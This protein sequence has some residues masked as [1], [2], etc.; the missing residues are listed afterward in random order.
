MNAIVV[1]GAGQAGLQIAECLR[2][3]GHSGP[4][5]LLGDERWPPYQR[6]PLSKKYLG[7]SVADERLFFRPLDYL[8][9]QAIDFR[10][11]TQVVAID[12]ANTRVLLANGEQLVYA[13]LALATGARPRMLP[14]PGAEHPAVCYLRGL[15][16][17]QGLLVKLAAAARVVVIGGGFIGL[18]VAATAC[19]AGKTVTV[20]EASE[21]L[22]ARAVAP[23]VSQ[24][25]AD[26]HR[27]QGVAL[28][29]G[30]QVTRLVPLA[31]GGLSVELNDGTALPAD[32]VLVGVGGL[33]NQELAAQAGLTCANGIVVDEFARTSDP[34]IV[35]AGDCTWHINR[36]YPTPL[37]LESVQNAVDQ[38]KIAASS[39]LGLAQPYQDLPWFWS[40]Q[41][42]VKLQI[43]GLSQS[44]DTAVV[45][46][47]AASGAFSVF[48]FAAGA[49]VAVDSVNR[50]ADHMLARKLLSASRAVT[51]G[52]AAD[53]NFDLKLLL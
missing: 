39:L 19:A 8:A 2:R 13:G 9:K 1:V 26:L 45:R 28:Q 18:E 30:A 43:A 15:E 22:L 17:A 42:D 51:P 52:Q 24:Y 27:T 10:A 41:Y 25:F 16:D 47:E 49:L 3:G 46:G 44:H 31:G 35:A 7:G 4:L 29:F 50:P 20:I 40:D 21:R 14:V 23:I 38:A 37:R 53:V 32:L 5:T 12:R 36:R 11:S 33:P 6:P 34:L 48:Y